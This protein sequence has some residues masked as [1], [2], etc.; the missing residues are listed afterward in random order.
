[1][2]DEFF[3]VHKSDVARSEHLVHIRKNT[4]RQGVKMGLFG[5][6][7][8]PSLLLLTLFFIE[9]FKG[10][11]GQALVHIIQLGLFV[12]VIKGIC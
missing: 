6:I 4:G 8:Q 2:Q 9:E 10:K 3:T 11:C 7:E 12:H 1:M 5:N